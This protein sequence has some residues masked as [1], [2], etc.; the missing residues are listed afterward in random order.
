MMIVVGGVCLPRQ[1][2]RGFGNNQ[3]EGWMFRPPGFSDKREYT[4]RIGALG[5]FK[6]EAGSRLIH[7]LFLRKLHMWGRMERQSFIRD[8]HA[9]SIAG[10]VENDLIK[11]KTGPKN[12][13]DT[14]TGVFTKTPPKPQKIKAVVSTGLYPRQSF[15]GLCYSER[16]KCLITLK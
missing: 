14:W 15:A 7:I 9:D 8:S 2:S 6:E 5:D 3:T 13:F 10:R 12:I 1:M 11:E 16:K 4:L